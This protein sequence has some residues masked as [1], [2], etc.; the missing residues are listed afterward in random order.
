MAMYFGAL[1]LRDRLA[2]LCGGPVRTVVIDIN[3]FPIDVA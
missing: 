3:D 2:Y 1:S